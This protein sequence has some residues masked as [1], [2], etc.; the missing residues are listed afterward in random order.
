[1]TQKKP[2][3]YTFHYWGAFVLGGLDPN[4]MMMMST[5]Y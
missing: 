4:E 5:L 2:L 1:M 3:T